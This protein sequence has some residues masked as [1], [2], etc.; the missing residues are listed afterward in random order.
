MQIFE[1]LLSKKGMIL[2]RI[3]ETIL[4]IDENKRIP[5]IG[6]LAQSYNVGRGTIQSALKYLEETGSIALQPKGHLGT[7]LRKKNIPLLLKYCGTERLAGIMP[8]PY[9]KKYE[10]LASGLSAECVKQGLDLSIA[11]MRGAALRLAEVNNG[12]YDFALV[13]KFSASEAM[14][15]YPELTVA[16]SFGNN[17]YVSKHAIIFADRNKYRIEDGMKIGVDSYSTDQEILI[18][19]ETM[20][21][22]VELVEL[23]YMH[24]LEHLKAKTID[25]TI[26]NIDE[27]DSERF[28]MMP[29]SSPIAKEEEYQI[30]EAVCV[31]RK[32]NKKADYIMNLLNLLDIREIQKLVETGDHIPKY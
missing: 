9:S 22:D 5:R 31:I 1:S 18:R 3:A 6:D 16:L 19:A 11:F 29:L 25:A 15:Q 4:F 17:T 24:L 14:K 32:D 30:G 8:L 26:W 23:N 20:N 12:R 28:N 2:Q 21:K 10:G 13:S 27:V 7:Y